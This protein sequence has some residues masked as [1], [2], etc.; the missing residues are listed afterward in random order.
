MMK[1]TVNS[2]SLLLLGAACMAAPAR[3]Q[4]S[5]AATT[6][7]SATQ[8][9]K[10]NGTGVVPPGVKLVPEMPPAGAPRPFEFPNATEKTLPNGLRVFVVTDHSEPAVA[11]RLLIMSAGGV[12][13]PSG[14]PG[15][16][17]MTANLLTQGTGKRS[18]KDI[19]EAIDF[20]GGSLNASSGKDATTVT[21]DVVKKDL[22]LGFD[23]MSDV[24]LHPAF[25]ADELERQ[26][27]QLLSGLTVQYSD[28][29]YLASVVFS[30]VVYGSSPYGSPGEGTPE[31]VKKLNRDDVAKFHDA[32][33]APNQ[34]LLAVAGDITPEEAFGV[35]EKYFGGWQKLDIPATVPAPPSMLSGQH[36]WLIDKPDAVQTQIRAGKLGIRRNDPD[37]IPV[38]VMNRIFGGGYNSLLNT[39]VRVKKGLTYGAYSQFNPQRYSGA[40]LVG[41]FT[42]T[43]A[44]VEATKLVVDLLSRMSSGGATP[45]Q[46]K[47]ARDYLAGVYPI[48]SETAEQ[49][50]G[51]VLTAAAYD[52]PADYNRT[53]PDKIRGVSLD[54]V[55]AMAK[56][57]L[58]TTDLD[59]V[60]T[61]NISAF[62]DALKK[63]F[64]DAKYDEIP[65][66]QVDV[67]APDLRKAK[68]VAVAATPESLE[69]GKQILAAAA[70]A[71]GGDAL[72]SVKTLAM[73]ENGK[74][75]GNS[76]VPISVKWTVAYP[77]HSHGD[78]SYGGQAITQI[79]DGKSAW[80]VISAQT[81]D[82]TRVMGEFER[83]IAL[84]GGGWG[85]YQQV[86]S[87]KI[88][89][90]AIGET[91][92]DGKKTLGV[93]VE[94]PF[95][96]VK[97]FFDPATHLLAA[98]RFQSVGQQGP[99]ESEQRWSD[100]RAVDGR[101]FA[102]ATVTYRDGKEFSES[103]YQDVKVNPP[104]DPSL[105]MKPEA[106]PASK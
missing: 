105:F 103:S 44:T 62:R 38:E 93:A 9:D 10:K 60:L 15:V 45:E 18:A 28:P 95:G 104:A 24:V 8:D 99:V 54:E 14:E 91:E 101:Q 76:D 94:E 66:E 83:G 12:K 57:Y 81:N 13:D 35:A 47:F 61:G 100:Y 2:L 88:T 29:E 6:Q 4:Q 56:R 69:Q 87:G 31:T 74:H 75:M 64:P 23:L 22:N 46:L 33:Y 58:A 7:G 106:A 80:I 98:A 26:R 27:Q 3:A 77:D 70:A 89:G 5:A 73:T 65:F 85:I 59:V 90:Q 41:T 11:A 39:E 19:A 20:V 30:R 1:R 40:F 52:L 71:S 92:I 16:A 17:A 67:L 82:V 49:V 102:F 72:A 51:R 48:Q 86:L 37:Y 63:V 97:L 36:I 32:N 68:A 50:S 25:S 53:Y 78:V 79:C 96:N 34:S 43:D 21:L 84:F 42:R 55:N